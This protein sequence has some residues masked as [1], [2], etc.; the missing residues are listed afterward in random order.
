MPVSGH[1]VRRQVARSSRYLNTNIPLT[2]DG[3]THD[4]AKNSPLSPN[5]AV[6]GVI[7]SMEKRD[8]PAR[9][10]IRFRINWLKSSLSSSFSPLFSLP[11]W[12]GSTNERK[13]KCFRGDIRRGDLASSWNLWKHCTVLRENLSSIPFW[14]GRIIARARSITPLPDHISV[15]KPC[16]NRPDL[17]RV[18]LEWIGVSCL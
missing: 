8:F 16:S 18:I 13:C 15:I 6:Y 2:P 12:I 1:I 9:A 4:S 14:K 10:S 5:L 11:W 3:L 17:W 7:L